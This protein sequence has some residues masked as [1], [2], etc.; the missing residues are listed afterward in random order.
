MLLLTAASSGDPTT[1]LLN[2]GA[3]GA[4]VVLLGVF[5]YGAYKRERDRADFLFNLLQQT[6]EK[7]SEKFADTLKETR[8]ALVASNDYLRDL[9][10]RRER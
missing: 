7:V 1:V 2:Y 10:R 8:D 3:I 4:M 5:S 9:A 6:N